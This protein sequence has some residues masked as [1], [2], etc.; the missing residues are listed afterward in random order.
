MGTESAPIELRTHPSISEIEP[1]SWD[2]LFV[3]VTP[4]DLAANGKTFPIAP[5]FDDILEAYE[6]QVAN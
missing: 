2:A 4:E 1:E 6:S 5:Y 3:D